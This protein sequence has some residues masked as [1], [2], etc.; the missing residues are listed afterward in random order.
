MKCVSISGE[1]KLVLKDKDIPV[2]KDGSVIIEVK[3][4]GICGSDIHNWDN[5][6]PVGLVMGHEFA[7][8]V[9]DPGSRIDLKKGD[10]V[11]GLPISPCGVCTIPLL[12]PVCLHSCNNSYVT[13]GFIFPPLILCI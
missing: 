11:T 12:A 13:A 3:S 5:G 8:V 7:G 10:R 9:V 1:K 2:S 6:A 4:C